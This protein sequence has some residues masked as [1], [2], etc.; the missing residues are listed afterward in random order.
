[1]NQPYDGNGWNKL[2]LTV[3]NITKVATQSKIP[4][5]SYQNLDA[6]GWH[7]ESYAIGVKYAYKGKRKTF[8]YPTYDFKIW[9]FIGVLENMKPSDDYV[10]SINTLLK[11]QMYVAGLRLAYVIEKIYG[12]NFLQ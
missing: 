1:M 11:R 12:T 4:L 6:I 3:T 9:I 10:Q 8:N 5:D 7:N 2:T